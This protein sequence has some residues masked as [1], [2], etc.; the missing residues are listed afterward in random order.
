MPSFDDRAALLGALREH[1]RRFQEVG[2]IRP[3][4]VSAPEYMRRLG[5]EGVL[6][7]ETAESLA[8]RYEACRFGCASPAPEE[9]AAELAALEAAATALETSPQE[10][11]AAL[12]QRWRQRWTPSSR[13]A[14]KP[15]EAAGR[16]AS[17]IL[18]TGKDPVSNGAVELRKQR[19]EQG[20]S[21]VWTFVAGAL[22]VWTVVVMAGSLWQRDR[23]LSALL[24]GRWGSPLASHL[25]GEAATRDQLRAAFARQRKRSGPTNLML[26]GDH[27]AQR[28]HYAE[29]IQVYHQSLERA[30]EYP[31]V[32]AL[33]SAKLA[34]LLLTADDPWYHDSLQAIR[35]ARRAVKLRPQKSDF[36]ET[37]AIAQSRIGAYDDAVESVSAALRYATFDHQKNHYSQQLEVFEADAAAHAPADR[38]ADSTDM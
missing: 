34:R 21:R 2:L 1:I 7:A 25:Q 8:T 11:R 27:Y 19:A 28:G 29:A 14:P 15:C 36:L 32:E 26:L 37:L 35:L 17:P 3:P 24:A 12:A 6:P 22:V 13:P 30:T 5:S 23:I 33:T 38:L 9:W 16:E 31:E 4:A 10:R 20:P 18:L